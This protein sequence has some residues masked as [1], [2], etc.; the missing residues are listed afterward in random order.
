MHLHHLQGD[1][2][3][4]SKSYKTCKVMIQ[5]FIDNTRCAVVGL[6]NKLYKMQ[7]KYIRIAEMYFHYFPF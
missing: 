4:N 2:F 1:L 6:D 7:G 3:S 5:K